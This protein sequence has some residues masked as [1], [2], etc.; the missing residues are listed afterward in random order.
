VKLGDRILSTV[1]YEVHL[2]VVR[3]ARFHRT[4]NEG[5]M[6]VASER[7]PTSVE[8]PLFDI[9]EF[10]DLL[11]PQADMGRVPAHVRLRI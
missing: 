5:I 3:V 11:D 9:P 1:L 2:G 10:F 8:T 7:L 6:D 4:E